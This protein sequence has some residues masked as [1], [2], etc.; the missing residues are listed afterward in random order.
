MEDNKR[1]VEINGVKM[2]VDLRHA[3]VIHQDLK[4]GTKV[5]LLKKEYGDN[6]KV[7]PGVVVGFEDF[8]SLPTIV[9]AYLDVDYSGAALKF[10]YFNA[11]A[12]SSEL[13]PAVEDYTMFEKDGVV[14]ALDRGIEAKKVE[15]EELNRKKAYFLKHF[16]AYFEPKEAKA[17]A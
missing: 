16:N 13:I 11:K 14:E 17:E 6:M 15:L 10:F 4:V 5:K 8:Q 2:E 12:E 1:I 7:F 3:K 9:V